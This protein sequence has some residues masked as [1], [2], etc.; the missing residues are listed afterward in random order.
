MSFG[1]PLYPDDFPAEGRVEALSQAWA[2]QL[3][4]AVS[5]HPEDW[6]MLQ[7]FGWMEA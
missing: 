4:D 5:R 7:R 6:H 1:T 2:T 3:A